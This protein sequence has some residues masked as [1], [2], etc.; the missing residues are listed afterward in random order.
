MTYNPNIP[1]PTDNLS[2]SQGQF[3]AN[4]DQ[5]NQQFEIDH[6]GFNT[7]S[8]NGDGFHKKVTLPGN[9]ATPSP[10]AGYGDIYTVTDANS[11]TRPFYK[12][13]ALAITYSMLP[14]RAFGRFAYSG[15]GSVVNIIG[16][17]MNI[18]SVTRPS[19][20]NYTVNLTAG[21]VFDSNFTVLITLENPTSK[22]L[23][24]QVTS[25]ISATSFQLSVFEVGGGFVDPT[26]ISLAVLYF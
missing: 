23:C 17:A 9:V 25:F 26:S 1:Q 11:I 6:T 8:G 16:N 14:I 19:L 4:F 5:L 21:A 18:S 20:G 7:G 24:Y 2:N 3:L 15:G 12:R 22:R 10:G 13:D